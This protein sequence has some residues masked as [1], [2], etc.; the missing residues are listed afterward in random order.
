MAEPAF[1]V[2]GLDS[3]GAPPGLDSAFSAE[4]L[5]VLGLAV[6]NPVFGVAGLELVGPP[7]DSD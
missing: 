1:L 3:G 6:L 5:V 2:P 4:E 7:V